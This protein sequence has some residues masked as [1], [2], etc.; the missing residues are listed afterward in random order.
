MPDNAGKTRGSCPG[1]ALLRPLCPAALQLSAG[2]PVGRREGGGGGC[3]DRTLATS[4]SGLGRSVKET[5][6]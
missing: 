1:E 3:K 4:P 2:A 5:L 6:T